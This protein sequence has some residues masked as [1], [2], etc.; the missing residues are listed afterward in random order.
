M[1]MFLDRYVK[2]RHVFIPRV[3][4]VSIQVDEED[5]LIARTTFDDS[6]KVASFGFFIAEDCKNSTIRDWAEAPYKRKISDVEH[7][8]YLN[9]YEKTSILF[10]LCYVEYSNGFSV[11]SRMTVKKI[12]G[13]FRNSQ[14]KSNVMYSSKNG[15]DCFAIADYKCHAI[16]GTFL[17]T[18]DYLPAVVNKG[19]GLKG[20]YSVCGLATYRL[21]TPQY[22][23]SSDSILKLDV[24]PDENMT[25][26]LCM[27]N[28]SGGEIYTA[29]Q[30]VV[31]GV[32]QSLLIESKNFKNTNG[33]PLSDYT[34]G[35]KFMISGDKEYA[36]NNVMW[37]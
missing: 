1:F 7:E 9:V 10:A 17:T 16:G 3:A 8:F 31:G 5:N 6:G 33:S 12:S 14:P 2:H 21:N 37:L 27:E 23:P 18:D 22:A 20:I 13:R 30:Y 34:Q 36:V 25:L 35:L 32:W 4:D 26:I 28:V 11:W 29:K 19:K 24:Y 15:C